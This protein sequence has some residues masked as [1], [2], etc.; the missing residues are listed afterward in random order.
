MIIDASVAFKWIVNEVDSDKAFAWL[1]SDDLLA[2]ALVYSE[3]GNALTRRI[4]GGELSG[5]G[6][7]ANLRRLEHILTV[8]DERPHMDLAL[9]MALSL[10]HSFYDCVYL[11]VAEAVDDE[12]LTADRRFF[13]KVAESVWQQRIRFLG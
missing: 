8:V 9:R 7:P 5:E 3:V 2:P 10:E 13:G 4:R 1:D 6:A 12:L 11:A